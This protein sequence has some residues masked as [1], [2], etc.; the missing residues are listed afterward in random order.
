MVRV[1]Y[2]V[3]IYTCATYWVFYVYLFSVRSFMYIF[4]YSIKFLLG[5]TL[6]LRVIA[7]MPCYWPSCYY[8]TLMNL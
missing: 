7:T 4:S 1:S 6:S 2:S 3:Y 5:K 8:S